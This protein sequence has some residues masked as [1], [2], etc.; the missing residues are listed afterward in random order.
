M[1]GWAQEEARV[2]CRPACYQLLM[3]DAKHSLPVEVRFYC[4]VSPL[5][6]KSLLLLLLQWG[7]VMRKTN[8]DCYYTPL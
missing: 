7:W 8:R 3:D 6:P 4:W 2:P 5:F 1:A